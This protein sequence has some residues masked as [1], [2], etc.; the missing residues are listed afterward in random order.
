MLFYERAVALNRD[1]HQKLRMEP[2]PDHY[3]FAAKTNAV[4]LAS[5]ELAEAARDHPIVFVGPQGG[6]FALAA[7][8]GLRN[9]ENLLVD[10]TGKW[11]PQTYIPAFARRYPFVLAEG[12]DKSVLTVCVDEAYAGLNE[13]RGEALFD[14]QGRE[15]EYLKRVLDFLRAFH[16]DMQRTRDFAARLHELGLLVS[17]VLTIEQQRDGR[18]D[19]Q[20]LEGVWV[21]DEEKLRGIDDARIVEIFRNGY[22]GWIYAHLLSLGNVRRLAGRLDRASR[23]T[24]DGAALEAKPQ[25]SDAGAAAPGGN[26][27]SRTKPSRKS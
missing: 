22:M 6:P 10:E 26:G 15:T 18:T 19:R 16:A 12:E 5:T 1:R 23:V 9:N 11:D 25:E 21:V 2:L 4:L 7:L 3:A 8:V 27:S 14:E 24:D 17:K 20:L 13:Q